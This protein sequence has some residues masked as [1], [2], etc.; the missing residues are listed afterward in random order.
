MADP[1]SYK[2]DMLEG[3]PYGSRGK[4]VKEVKCK[5]CK[6]EYPKQEIVKVTGIEYYGPIAPKLKTRMVSILI[7]NKCFCK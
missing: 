7:C 3:H 4:R 5:M 6:K 2:R 1:D